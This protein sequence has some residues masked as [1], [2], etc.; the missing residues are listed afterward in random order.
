MDYSR[1]YAAFIKARRASPPGE[2]EYVEKH[3]IAPRCLGGG[4]EP[5]NLIRLTPEDHFFAHLLLAKIH[6]GRLWAPIALMIGKGQ[7]KHRPIVSRLY[8]GWASRAMGRARSGTNAP[9]YDPTPHLLAHESGRHWRGP[10]LDMSE[11]L[12]LSRSVANMLIKGRVKSAAG[13]RLADTDADDVGRKGGSRHPMY[14]A[15]EVRLVHVDGRK[16]LGTQHEFHCE[17]GLSA[18]AASQLFRGKISIAGGWY[19]EGATPPKIGRGA[20]WQ[21]K[22]DRERKALQPKAVLGDKR[23]FAFLHRATGE[24]FTGRR[25]EMRKRTGLRS[26]QLQTLFT[27]R[28]KQVWG[29]SLAPGQ[30]IAPHV[31]RGPPAVHAFVNVETGERVSA[32]VPDLARRCGVA[33][34]SVRALLT[35]RCKQIRGWT[36]E[37]AR[38]TVAR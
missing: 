24:T 9:Q 34:N 13:W 19:I 36:L 32:S 20:R 15:E 6:G 11:D 2:G 35:G 25:A 37:K 17:H 14:R 28:Q 3:H 7:K 38:E 12:G 8:Y 1:I 26:C 10:Q 23:V 33:N 16:F 29:W 31:K 5:E 4:D 22:L 21:A 18:S 30:E 27:G